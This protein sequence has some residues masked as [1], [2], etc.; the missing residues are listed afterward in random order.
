MRLHP[1]SFLGAFDMSTCR[2]FVMSIKMGALLH[3]IYDVHNLL[4]YLVGSFHGAGF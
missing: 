3:R 2:D 1:L 4:S